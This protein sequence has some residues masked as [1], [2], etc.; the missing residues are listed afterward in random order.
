LILKSILIMKKVKIML[1]AITVLAGVG[2]ALAFKAKKFNS[3]LYCTSGNPAQGAKC[4][5]EKDFF[6]LTWT[7][8]NQPSAGLSTCTD[9]ENGA[10]CQQT[11]TYAD[12]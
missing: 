2:G 5:V 3:V 1:I 6:S 8:Q 4:N 7:E 11:T 9:V 12:Q 10:G